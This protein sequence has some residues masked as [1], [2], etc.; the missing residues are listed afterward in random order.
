MVTYWVPLKQVGYVCR[1]MYV[2]MY[3]CMH[4]DVYVL[5][6]VLRIYHQVRR[7]Y[8]FW[9]WAFP[10]SF[11]SAVASFLF[12][13]FF[14]V[15]FFPSLLAPGISVAGNC[16]NN[17]LNIVFDLPFFF[18]SEFGIFEYLVSSAQWMVSG[19]LMLL[20][21]F[22]G[23][24]CV[25]CFRN[26]SVVFSVITAAWI[27]GCSVSFFWFLDGL[28]VHLDVTNI[29]SLFVCLFVCLFSFFLSFGFGVGLEL[30]ETLDLCFA[31]FKDFFFLW[32]L[33]RFWQ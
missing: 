29:S 4:D 12:F 23:G 14:V 7:P 2:C 9:G 27:H 32:F 19:V 11:F 17:P 28:D 20:Y 30:T 26:W 1:Y 10:K 25:F 16:Y 33:R 8:V 13:F 6:Y 22:L 24:G 5:I 21:L 18:P 3:V 15:F 31:F